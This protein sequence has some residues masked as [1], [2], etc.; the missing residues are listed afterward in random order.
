MESEH[1]GKLDIRSYVE[2]DACAKK[3][4]PIKQIMRPTVVVEDIFV[5]SLSTQE[6]SAVI[7]STMIDM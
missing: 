2:Y 3:M 1:E 7:K 6:V 5:A 4:K